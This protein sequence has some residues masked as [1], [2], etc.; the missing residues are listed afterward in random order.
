MLYND[1]PIH[2][3][4]KIDTTAHPFDYMSWK[5]KDGV[6]KLAVDM[7]GGMSYGDESSLSP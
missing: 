6:T 5:L 3:F 2:V 1:V 4:L 7:V